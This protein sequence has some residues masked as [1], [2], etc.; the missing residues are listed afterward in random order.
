MITIKYAYREQHK[1]TSIKIL[2]NLCIN[3]NVHI[4]ADYE[5]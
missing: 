4:I 5:K 1:I 2:S 3:I